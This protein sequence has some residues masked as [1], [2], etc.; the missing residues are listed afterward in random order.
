MPLMQRSHGIVIFVTLATAP[1]AVS[2]QGQLTPGQ[3][4]ARL[5][6]GAAFLKSG[7]TE[8]ATKTFAAVADADPTNWQARSLLVLAHLS[9]R[10]LDKVDV[11]VNRLKTQNAPAATVAAV[12]RQVAAVRQTMR[13]RDEL[14]RLLDA[15]KWQEALTSIDA[16]ALADSRKQLLRGYVAALRGEFDAIRSTR[17]STRASRSARRSF[18]QRVSARWSRSMSSATATAG[19]CRARCDDVSGRRRSAG[20]SRLH[21]RKCA[22]ATV[23]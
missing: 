11:E 2:A 1:L 19:S 22:P 16:G 9:V 14:A 18:K 23:G 13:V 6:V 3:A 10:A 15:G 5:E 20:H 4:R 17:R 21:G 7:D 8:L 12:E